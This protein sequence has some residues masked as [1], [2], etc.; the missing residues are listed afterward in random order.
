MDCLDRTDY[1]WWT[2]VS[3]QQWT[4]VD[5]IVQLVVKRQVWGNQ[6]SVQVVE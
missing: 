3:K 4:S 6:S 5:S 1:F 2:A